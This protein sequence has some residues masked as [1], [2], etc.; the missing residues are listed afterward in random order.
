M[1]DKVLIIESKI[2][3]MATA[4]ESLATEMQK[5]SLAVSNQEVLLEKMANLK[6]NTDNSID[7]LHKRI[8]E[9]EITQHS[10]REKCLEK[11]NDKLTI[12][13][14][15]DEIKRT[16]LKANIKSNQKRID[17]IDGMVVWGTRGIIGALVT[18]AIGLLF[19]FVRN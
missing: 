17:K 14:K 19:Y 8:D 7:R 2:G 15:D 3:N 13:Q 10:F 9:M 4:I 16:E 18:G 11:A 5:M 1:E 6:D 12:A